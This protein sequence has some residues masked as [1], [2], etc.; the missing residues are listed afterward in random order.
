MKWG[1]LDDDDDEDD[2]VPLAPPMTQSGGFTNQTQY[3]E[4]NSQNF[5]Y[6]S[7]YR[8]PPQNF[9]DSNDHGATFEN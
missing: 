9:N 7:G 6:N 2:D 1:D 3:V 4:M 8:P 5:N